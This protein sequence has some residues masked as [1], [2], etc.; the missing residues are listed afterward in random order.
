MAKT[1]FKYKN[2]DVSVTLMR[3]ERNKGDNLAPAFWRITCNRKHKYYP[4]GFSF[5]LP[6]WDDFVNRD[7]HKDKEIKMTLENYR[8]K[9]LKT[10]INS[11][12]EENN[13][14]FETLDHKLGKS[15]ILTVNDAFRAKITDLN[16]DFKVGNATIYRT[17]LNALIRFQFYRKIKSKTAKQLFIEE[18]ISKKY[19]TKGKEVLNVV[20]DINFDDITVKFLSDCEDFWSSI[21]IQY[22]TIG[23]YMR[24]LRAIINNGEDP[25]LTGNRYPFG[26]GKNKYS[27]PEGRR[28]SIALDIE[29]IWK[30]EDFE[31]DNHGLILARDIFVFMFYCNGLN[32]GDLCRLQY[33]DIDGASQEIVFQRKKT[34]DTKKKKSPEPIY[35]PILPPM[36][37]IINRHGNK[38]QDGYIFPFLNGIERL[39]QNEKKIKDA[40]QLALN[41]INGSL[42][43]IAAQLGIDRN[44]STAY[45]RNS[46]ITYLTSEMYI[47]EIFVKQMVGHSTG[48]NVTAGY[49]NPSA[50]KRR[51]VNSNL[52]NPNKK[53]NTISLLA[54]NS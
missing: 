53:Y 2:R 1:I 24:T 41:P 30:I 6:D 51:E 25:Y 40:I 3:K 42:K 44:L 47:S 19:K 23:I 20:A 16:K 13:F 49:N 18:C 11:L 5:S 54:V 15:D 43:V 7:L 39:D 26:E 14:S 48:K 22:A 52:L 28:R 12:V 38:E 50:K 35:A 4:S 37:E 8:D 33:K 29:D 46:Y 27:I 32:F 34:R 10:I 9:T 45:T 31:T 36:I 17:T 21:G